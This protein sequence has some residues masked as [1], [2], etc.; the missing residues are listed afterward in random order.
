M[1]VLEVR[2]YF[3]TERFLCRLFVAALADDTG[4]ERCPPAACDLPFSVS[5]RCCKRCS[6]SPSFSGAMHLLHRV[7]AIYDHNDK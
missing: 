2:T 7:R 4:C 1:Q 3:C 5:M 6:S